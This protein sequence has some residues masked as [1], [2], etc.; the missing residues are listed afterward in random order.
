MYYST[1][2]ISVE[3]AT[4]PGWRTTVWGL[5]NYVPKGPDLVINK[6][7]LEK[8][9]IMHAFLTERIIRCSYEMT[10]FVHGSRDKPLK[11]QN[12]CFKTVG[13]ERFCYANLLV[14]FNS[15]GSH[16]SSTC[17]W[18]LI[19]LCSIMTQLS[20]TSLFSD[21]TVLN[22]LLQSQCTM[23]SLKILLLSIKNSFLRW[24]LCFS[25][26]STLLIAQKIC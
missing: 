13:R 8:F 15:P 19:I 1:F 26:Q 5:L 21:L 18:P 23:T 7:D 24:S 16:F 4:T 2:K 11:Y 17:C 12:H 3:L 22:R 6:R 20:F 14:Y 25:F 9:V 10:V